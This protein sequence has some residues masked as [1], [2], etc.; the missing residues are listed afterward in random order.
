VKHVHAVKS[1]ALMSTTH[2]IEVC[3]CGATR[4]VRSGKAEAWH[5][6]QLC[7]H[8]YEEEQGA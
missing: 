1:T 7:V 3:D 2:T 8:G 5:A 6:C 4:S